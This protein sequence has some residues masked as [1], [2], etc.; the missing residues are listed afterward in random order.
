M[1]A[2]SL[3]DGAVTHRILPDIDLITEIE[4]ELG[5]LSQIRRAL[6]EE[7]LRISDLVVMVQMMLQAAGVTA[8]YRML[9]NRILRDGAATYRQAVRD[10][11]DFV[12]G[13]DI[14]KDKI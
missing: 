5:P 8:D 11:L 13:P 3:K 12:L 9:G 2:V 4:H 10:L 1:K 7:R 6:C 14:T